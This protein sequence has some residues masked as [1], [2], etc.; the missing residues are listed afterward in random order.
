[1]G[2]ESGI[3]FKQLLAQLFA[4]INEHP[5]V[6][7]LNREECN[8]MNDCIHLFDL[9]VDGLNRKTVAGTDGRHF[10]RKG[11][12]GIGR[13]GGTPTPTNEKRAFNF[14]WFLWDIRW[15]V[16]KSLGFQQNH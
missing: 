16:K 1:M 7:H 9:T 10:K 15:T 6:N 5:T 3:Q 12:E 13:K 4:N 11:M 14:F 2:G 8:Q